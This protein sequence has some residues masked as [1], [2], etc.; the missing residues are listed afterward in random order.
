MLC[1]I[2]GCRCLVVSIVEAVA[3]CSAHC[4]SNL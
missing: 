1:I 2:S 4:I 3:V